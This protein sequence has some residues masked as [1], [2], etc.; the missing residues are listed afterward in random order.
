MR[1]SAVPERETCWGMA[2]GGGRRA[3]AT[4]HGATAGRRE[5]TLI[6]VPPL[7]LFS[8]ELAMGEAWARG[9]GGGGG[10]LGSAEDGALGRRVEGE[11][12]LGVLCV[13]RD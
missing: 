4:A 6:L 8:K 11:E 7:T 3:G 2:M 13:C 10:E 9:G 1:A 5:A 12:G